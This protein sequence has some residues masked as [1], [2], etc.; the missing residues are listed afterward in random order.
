MVEKKATGMWEVNGELT[1]LFETINHG[2]YCN[3]NEIFERHPR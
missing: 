2:D 1:P 3:Q